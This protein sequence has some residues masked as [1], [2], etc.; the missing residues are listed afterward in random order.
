[1]KR[2]VNK[3]VVNLKIIYFTEHKPSNNKATRT[4]FNFYNGV[5][6]NVRS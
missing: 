1:M 4:F 2:L 3:N 5:N 6:S